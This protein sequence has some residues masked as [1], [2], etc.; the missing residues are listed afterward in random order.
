MKVHH[1][2][3]STTC[4][5]PKSIAHI[6]SLKGVPERSGL[7]DV[8]HSRAKVISFRDRANA[9]M[10]SNPFNTT[11][12]VSEQTSALTATSY[13]RY[14]LLTQFITGKE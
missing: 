5:N 4:H 1:F 13:Q 3:S 11:H 6:H 9:R 7:V 12:V 10:R 14:N 8:F 2:T